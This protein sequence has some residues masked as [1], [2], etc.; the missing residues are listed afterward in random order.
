MHVAGLVGLAG[1]V[2]T[3]QLKSTTPVKLFDGVTVIVAV[4]PVAAPAAKLIA[5]LLVS[6]IAGAG[7]AVTVTPTP[8]LAV[9]APLVPVTVAVYVPG[10]VVNVVETVTVDVPA[11]V[12]VMSTGDTALH[13]AGLVAAT[14]VTAQVNATLPVNPAAGV[15]VNF[16]VSPV[17]A[18]ACKLIAPLLV[19]AKLGGA[20]TVTATPVDEVILPVDASLPVTV[21]V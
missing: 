15:I 2:V 17:V 16:A 13:V 21:M 3:A 7:G 6:V 18:P 19:S 5:P 8:V 20:V 14:G 1:V 10:V 11:A 9:I 4:F 12:P